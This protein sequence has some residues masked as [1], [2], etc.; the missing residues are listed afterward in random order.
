MFGTE[1]PFVRTTSRLWGNGFTKT[2]KKKV[3]AKDTTKWRA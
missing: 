1:D 2:K 3:T